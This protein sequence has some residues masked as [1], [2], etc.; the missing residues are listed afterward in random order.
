MYRILPVSFLLFTACTALAPNVPTTEDAD[1]ICSTI[2]QP[3]C[4]KIA[5]QCMKAP[6]DPVL[7]TFDNE[8]VAKAL[9]A[10]DLVDGECEEGN[11]R[12]ESLKGQ[13]VDYGASEG[14]LSI[15]EGEGPFPAVILIHEWWGLNDNIKWYADRFAQQGYV[16]LAVDLYN[17]ESTEDRERA[18]ALA[19]R[20]RE[21]M[22]DAFTNLQSAVVFLKSRSD[23]LQESIASVGW[24]FG[25]GWSYQMAKNDLG[26]AA[27]VI[28]Y[29]QF[30]PKDDLATMRAAIMG[31][32][33]EDDQSIPV[34]DVK[35]FR[36]ALQTLSGTHQV[37]LYENEGHGFARELT[38]ENAKKAWARTLEFLREEL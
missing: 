3:V 34:D 38:S 18:G 12:E 6:C 2:S 7:Q 8:C 5:V 23:V 11:D 27:S 28:Y 33:G 14:Y 16:A 20:V 10:F 32:F 31:H 4:G 36:A 22:D 1:T 30:N 13:N 24:C 29:G 9:G 15:P 19:G 17:G 21:H 26:V 25:G 35:A 37:F